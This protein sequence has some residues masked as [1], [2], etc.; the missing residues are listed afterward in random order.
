MDFRSF[1]R[2]PPY[3]PRT[4][5]YLR[6]HGALPPQQLL[7]IVMA[8]FN[9][10]N[11]NNFRDGTNLADLMLGRGGADAL[12][13]LDG[14]DTL[15]G[16]DGNDGLDGGG[17]YDSVL[18]VAGSEVRAGQSGSETQAWGDTRGKQRGRARP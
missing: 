9:L 1:P 18:G 6:D 15:G 13:G 5:L 3:A 4:H 17:G 8:V 7:E 2:V 11:K 14:D 16:G 12:N 10:N